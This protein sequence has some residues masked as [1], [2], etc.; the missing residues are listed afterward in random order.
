MDLSV[1]IFFILNALVWIGYSGVCLGYP[2]LL[3][4]LGVFA[5]TGW[6]EQVE[7]RAMYGGAQMGIGLFA[8]ASALHKKHQTTA[9]LFFFFL[10]LGLALTRAVGMYIDGPSS[11]FAVSFDGTMNPAS[12]NSGALW[13]FEVPMFVYAFVL[14][15]QGK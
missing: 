3:A 12:Y 5:Q 15:F 11:A 13:F 6:I 7:V 2:E 10:F 1:R 14:R 9:I 8:L 4:D